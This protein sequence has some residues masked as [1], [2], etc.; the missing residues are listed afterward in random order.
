MADAKQKDRIERAEVRREALKSPRAAAVA[1]ILF[2]ITFSVSL[3]LIRLALPEV[4]DI[5]SPPSWLETM[6]PRFQLR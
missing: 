6:R 4:S 1:G 2:A 3:L 5:T